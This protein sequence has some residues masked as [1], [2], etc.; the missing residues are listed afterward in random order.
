MFHLSLVRIVFVK[1]Q[2]LKSFELSYPLKTLSLDTFSQERPQQ[3]LFPCS[4]PAGLDG[5]E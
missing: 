2:F 3:S 1:V 5:V 4:S